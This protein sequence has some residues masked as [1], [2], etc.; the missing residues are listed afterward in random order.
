MERLPPDED[1]P[2]EEPDGMD[3]LEPEPELPEGILELL[4]PLDPD[5]PLD[6]EEGDEEGEPGEEGMLEDDC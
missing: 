4:P 3:E 2:P 6:E 5:E 1:A